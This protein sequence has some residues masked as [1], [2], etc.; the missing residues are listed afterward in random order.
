MDTEVNDGPLDNAKSRDRRKGRRTICRSESLRR[1][2]RN[3]CFISALLLATCAAEAA[4][5]VMPYAKWPAEGGGVSRNVAS[6]AA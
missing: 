6:M 5:L 3:V 4:V 2:L 1:S